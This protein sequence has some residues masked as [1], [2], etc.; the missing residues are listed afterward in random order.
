MLEISSPNINGGAFTDITDVSVGGSF[1]SGGYNSQIN[2]GFQSPIGGRQAWT[3]NS[4]GYITTVANLGPNLVGQTV[5]LRFRMASDSSQSGTGWRV[6]GI[7]VS[8]GSV[9]CGPVIAAVPPAVLAAESYGP[10]NNAPDPGE[11]VM[12][13]LTLANQG[14]NST[15]NLIATLLST[16]GVTSPSNPQSYGVVTGG[17]G[18]ATRS[19]TFTARGTCGSNITL[20]LALQDGAINLGTVAFTM[21]LGVTTSSTTSFSNTTAMTIPAAV[22]EQAQGPRPTSILPTLSC[23]DSPARSPR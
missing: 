22:T 12:V 11:T 9:C 6:D 5:K 13:N 17:G 10:G 2:T 19:F 23:P 15:G 20:T 18:S 7:V 3:G 4:G 14:S 8:N 21:K 1:V 16:G